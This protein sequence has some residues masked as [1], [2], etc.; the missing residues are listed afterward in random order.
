MIDDFEPAPQQDIDTRRSGGRPL[1]SLGQ[2]VATPAALAVL[3]AANTLAATL[4]SRHV[5]GEWDQ[6]DAHDRAM[7]EA[8]LR[9]GER[10]FSVYTVASQ[11]LYVI[12]EAVSD[13]GA[14]ASTCILLPSEY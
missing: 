2:C 9:N 14:R 10:I 3:H 5:Q 11:R 4:L 7:N 13:N 12:T 6:L 8:A 1:F